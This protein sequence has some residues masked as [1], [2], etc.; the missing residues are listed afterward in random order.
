MSMSYPFYK[1]SNGVRSPPFVDVGS[2]AAR[3]PP[4]DLKWLSA[5]D[6]AELFE[7]NEIN[8]NTF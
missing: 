8:R 1:V 5:P 3:S 6:F 7:D 4:M 2:S